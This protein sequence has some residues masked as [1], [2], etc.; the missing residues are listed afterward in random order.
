MAI[1]RTTPKPTRDPVRWEV[2]A[3]GVAI[4]M[5][6]FEDKVV[7]LLK[8][9]KGASTP[10]YSEEEVH[11]LRRDVI[12]RL[13]PHLKKKEFDDEPRPEGT[14]RREENSLTDDPVPHPNNSEC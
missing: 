12:G 1:S 3:P 8:A 6:E 2:P 9:T 4:Q 14:S 10:E 7:R 5:V 11:V 13:S